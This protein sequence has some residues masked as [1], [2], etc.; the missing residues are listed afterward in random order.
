MTYKEW[1][2]LYHCLKDIVER[3]YLTN[4]Y[5]DERIYM[6][7]QGS[8]GCKRIFIDK[9]GDVYHHPVYGSPEF[10]YTESKF[11]IDDM[12]RNILSLL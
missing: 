7:I 10:L 5:G 9:S 8:C 1:K 2:K 6:P 11:D 3:V 12:V 4:I